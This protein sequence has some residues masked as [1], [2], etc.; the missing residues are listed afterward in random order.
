VGIAKFIGRVSLFGLALAGGA[1]GVV[2]YFG[3]D[4][5]KPSACSGG[6]VGGHLSNGKRLP[7]SGANFSAY[8]LAGYLAGRT[9]MHGLARDAVLDAYKELEQTA[10]EQRYVYAEAGWPFGGAFPPHRSH[11]NGTSVD[12]MV[13]LRTDRGASVQ[14]TT[15]IFNKLGYNVRFDDEGY[16][17]NGVRI[18]FEAIAQ[19]LVALDKAARKHGIK[20]N[21]VIFEPSLQKHLFA[22]ASGQPLAQRMSFMD[23]PAW[24][25]HDQHYH[26]DFTI[27]CR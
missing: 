23:R 22:T 5:G 10:P 17:A 6:V 8:H 21:R 19:H 9:F 24:V 7:L 14:V 3:I 4:D 2:A 12:F 26:V 25:R 1:A 27:P 11:S 20:I 13:P 16:G 18:D 15:S